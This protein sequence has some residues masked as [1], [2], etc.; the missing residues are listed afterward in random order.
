[1]AGSAYLDLLDATTVIIMKFAHI[2]ACLLE[3]L[4]C[5][6][7][8]FVDNLARPVHVHQFA[9]CISIPS[10]VCHLQELN[11][12]GRSLI[13]LKLLWIALEL[14]LS[15][16]STLFDLLRPVTT[17]CA[18]LRRKQHLLVKSHLV[19]DTW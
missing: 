3:E 17:C 16:C 8:V 12:T 19:E 6:P 10:T 14:H 18:L 1:M 11:G 7:E 5:L 2:I 9:S 13:L 4:Q 15:V